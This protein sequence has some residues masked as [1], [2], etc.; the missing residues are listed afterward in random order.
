MPH[1]RGWG[2]HTQKPRAGLEAGEPWAGAFIVVSVGRCVGEAGQAALEL[3]SLNH[4]TGLWG[5]GAAP[6]RL[7]PT[8]GAIKASG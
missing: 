5:L 7:E 3:A 1:R 2:T 6:R 8:P 4:F